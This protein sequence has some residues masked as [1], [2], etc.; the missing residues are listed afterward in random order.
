MDEQPK[1]EAT[2]D[3]LNKPILEIENKK[4]RSWPYY[5]IVAIIFLGIGMFISSNFTGRV[6]G[7]DASEIKPADLSVKVSSYIKENL[8]R[9]GYELTIESVGKENGMYKIGMNVTS[10]QGAIP[11]SSYVTA[12]GKL[13]FLNQPLELDKKIEQPAEEPAPEDTGPV[14]KV[15]KPAVDFYVMSFCPYGQQFENN[16]YPVVQALGDEFTATPHFVIYSNYGS[17]YPNYCID[18]ENKYCSLHGIKE[19]N[20][21]VRQMCVWKYFPNKFWEY[22]MAINSNCNS[23]NIEE[24]WEGQAK[25]LGI[26]TSVISTCF[27]SEAT[28]LLQAEVEL[29]QQF[30]VSGSPTVFLNGKQY[31]GSRNPEIMKQAVCNTFK[32]A[33]DACTIS[34]EG[35]QTNTAA[36]SCG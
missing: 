2:A 8:L 4:S 26:D 31:A 24:C 5:L 13:L 35:T 34:L 32:T 12:D 7:P 6:V 30:D 18:K 23:G 19:L 25:A 15:D 22:L 9:E 3:T 17:G 1:P 11:V 14:E 16:F 21:D 33:P 20:E 10:P 29:N 36:G 28:K 27:S